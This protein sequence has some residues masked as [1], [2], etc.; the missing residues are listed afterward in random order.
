MNTQANALRSQLLTPAVISAKRQIYWALRR[1]FWESRWIYLT[2]LAVSALFLLG[3]LI[4]LPMHGLSALDTAKRET[5]IFP[6]DMAAGLLMGTFLFVAMF[7]CV[8]TLQE[9][10]AIAASCSGSRC[11]SLMSR[12]CSQKQA[13]RSWYFR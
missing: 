2:P 6:Y 3:F 4:H 5:V 12:P 9:S 11:R 7:Y 8:E 10:G 1:E 13:S